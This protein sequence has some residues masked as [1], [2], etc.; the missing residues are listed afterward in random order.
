[1]GP[2]PT[3]DLPKQLNIQSTHSEDKEACTYTY[4][5][6]NIFLIDRESKKCVFKF[7][8]SDFILK[9]HIYS[10]LYAW[11]T[12][13]YFNGNLIYKWASIID[14]AK[15]LFVPTADSLRVRLSFDTMPSTPKLW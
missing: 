3:S 7:D 13:A 4:T 6:I 12:Y 11:F 14:P 8:V 2:K 15:I 1:M 10:T 9:A 5:Q